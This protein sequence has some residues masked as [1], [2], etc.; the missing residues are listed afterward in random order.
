MQDLTPYVICLL[1]MAGCS[2]LPRQEFDLSGQD[3]ENFTIWMMSDIQPRTK[4]ERSHFQLA[5]DDMDSLSRDIDLAIIA[6]DLLQS[7]SEEED[8]QWFLQARNNLHEADW[9]EIAGNHDARNAE[10]FRTFIGKP[11][12]YGVLTGNVLLLMLSDESGSSETNISA[13]AFN[14]WRDMVINNQ[15]RIIITVTHAQLKQSGLFTSSASSRNIHDS[16]R[17]AEVL[18][19]YRVAVWASGHSHLPSRFTGKIRLQEEL[20]GTVFVNVSAI[21]DDSFMDSESRLLVLTEGSN[22]LWIRSRNH[23]KSRFDTNLDTMIPLQKYFHQESSEPVL[24]LP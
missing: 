12:Y 18:K 14:W 23:S 22:K 10:L 15:D 2:N 16:D 7:H 19:Q 17:F 20:G 1:L 11:A 3:E 21:R 13:A 4:D 6:G 24:L 8:Y 5:I 9:F